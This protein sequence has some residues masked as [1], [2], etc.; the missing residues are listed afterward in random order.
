MTTKPQSLEGH[1][2]G[3]PPDYARQLVGKSAPGVTAEVACPSCEGTGQEPPAYE[4]HWSSKKYPCQDC[5]GT[6]TATEQAQ[7]CDLPPKGWH[8]SRGKGH[9]GPC[10]S[11]ENE[12]EPVIS[13]RRSEWMALSPQ[14]QEKLLQ[15]TG[16]GSRAIRLA[17]AQAAQ[18]MKD[19]PLLASPQSAAQARQLVGKSAPTPSACTCVYATA[20]NTESVRKGYVMG[21]YVKEE[22]AAC[23][24]IDAAPTA[25]ET[26]ES[27]ALQG[28]ASE[29]EAFEAWALSD[30]GGWWDD[31][32]VRVGDGYKAGAVTKQWVGWQ[33]R[34]ALTGQAAP[35]AVE[36]GRERELLEALR[37]LA[38]AGVEAWG[39]ERPCVR[40]ALRVLAAPAVVA[41]PSLPAQQEGTP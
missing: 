6:G 32:I 16:A 9:G 15:I 34:A 10:A 38:D 14:A 41:E 37:D 4:G 8:C 2:F 39:E 7:E 36:A 20:A 19:K 27:A 1:E 17:D 28:V 40:E 30:D 23:K 31:A 18:D 13:I 11:V 25:P 33:A 26:A 29:R 3:T 12:A 21:G 22:C 24:A 5:E 35:A